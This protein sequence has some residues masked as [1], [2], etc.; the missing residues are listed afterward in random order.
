[1]LLSTLLFLF[2]SIISK[3][4]MICKSK[5]KET[6][7][8]LSLDIFAPAPPDSVGGVYL[9]MTEAENEK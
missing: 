9:A 6:P 8:S 7:V 3:A 2:F 4:C 1:M 5:T